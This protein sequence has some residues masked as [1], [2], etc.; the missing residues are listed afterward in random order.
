MVKKKYFIGDV[1]EY[2]LPGGERRVGFVLEHYY[3][4][5][6]YRVS[7]EDRPKTL[8]AVMVKEDQITHKLIRQDVSK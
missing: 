5:Q 4:S 8:E 1:V 2:K 7:A 3:M 6:V